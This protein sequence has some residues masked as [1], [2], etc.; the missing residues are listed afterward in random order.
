MSTQAASAPRVTGL[1]HRAG[2]QVPLLAGAEWIVVALWLAGDIR[3]YLAFGR[4]ALLLLIAAVL[5]LLPR[6][7]KLCFCLAGTSH[8]YSPAL[9]VWLLGLFIPEHVI[10][11]T[12]LLMPHLL[13]FLLVMILLVTQLLIP[14]LAT[15]EV[16]RRRYLNSSVLLTAFAVFYFLA[17]T[18]LA[19]AKLRAFGYVGQDIG[20]FMQCLYTGMHGQLFSSNQYHDLLYT[21]TVTTD[22]ASHNQPVLF[23]LLPIYW[24]FPHAETLF[25]VR[26]VCLALSAYPAY[27]LVRY[28]LAPVPAAIL[29]C[30][31]LLAPAMLFQNFY[32]YA[33]LSMAGLPLLFALLFYYRSQYLPYIASLLLCLFIREDL[34]LAV[35]GM[36][37]VA[38][39]TRRRYKWSI[40]PL[41]IGASWGLFTWAWL[42]PHFQHGATSAVES[43]FAYLGS[44]PTS[45]AH[46]ALMHPGLILTHK[47]IVYLKQIFT[48]FGAVLPFFSPASAVSFPFLLINL[49][50][51]PGCNA[52]IVFRHYSLVPS[53]LLL[54][55]TAMAVSWMGARSGFRSLKPAML[56]FA[57]LL[58]SAGTTILSIGTTE[59]GWWHTAKWQH[60]AREVAA[61]LP[62]HASVA[63]PRYMLPLT[64]N[65]DRVYQTLRLLDYHHP[66]ANIVVV[67]RDSQRMGVTPVWQDHYDLL[68]DQLKDDS[69][70]TPIYT[71]DNYVVYRLIGTPL[72][73]LRPES[74]RQ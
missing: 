11:S 29:T 40:V 18:V 69:R 4:F 9:W 74:S 6:A 46:E 70:F 8:D 45:M 39:L 7:V 17:A 2:W 24:L 71:S 57:L 10:G 26:N 25:V 3:Y 41:A 19:I 68:L 34:A 22:F 64:A 59:I 52:A 1:P 47:A 13:P 12:T 20:Y 33:P 37:L 5:L 35:M 62:P 28:R 67:D 55:G 44:T 43:C 38:L 48:P 16:P 53:I 72:S 31:L 60:E 61:S 36:G 51:D 15:S 66:N 32:D 65:R 54:P 23:M 58:A 50:G 21:R 73:S 14:L 49:A 42:L 30:A 63:V 27:Q 56:A